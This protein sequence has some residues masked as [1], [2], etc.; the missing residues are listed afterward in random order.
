MRA[1]CGI[2][3]N[4]V[5]A[6]VRDVRDIL[7]VEYCKCY[8]SYNDAVRLRA[9]CLLFITDTAMVRLCVVLQ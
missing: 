3:M 6:C 2:R 8:Y 1:A 7:Y 4:T 5:G 9:V